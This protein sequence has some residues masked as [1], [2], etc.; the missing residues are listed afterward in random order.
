[1]KPFQIPGTHHEK[2]FCSECGSALPSVQ[3]D[4]SLLVVPAGCLDS[5][6][7]IPPNAHICCSSRAEWDDG[8][9]RVQELDGLP[10]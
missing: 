5:P 8:L 7:D 9:D 3:M 10:R 1:M 4:G 2:S 6:I